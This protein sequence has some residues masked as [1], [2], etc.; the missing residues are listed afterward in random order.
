VFDLDRQLIDKTGVKDRFAIHLEF[1]TEPAPAQPTALVNLVRALEELLRL[2]LISTTGR[3]SW[4][5]IEQI[6]RPR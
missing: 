4:V 6:E 3:R 5:Q 1:E 2:T